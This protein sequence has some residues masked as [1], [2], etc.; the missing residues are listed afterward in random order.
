MAVRPS[1]SSTKLR[2]SL[3]FTSFPLTTLYLLAHI[4][5]ISGVVQSRPVV[6]HLVGLGGSL[7]GRV[8]GVVLVLVGCKKEGRMSVIL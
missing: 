3:S 6:V 7:E 5:N 2:V 1:S 4:F 8:A